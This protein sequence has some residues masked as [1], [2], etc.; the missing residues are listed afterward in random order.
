MLL[1]SISKWPPH[2]LRSL[3][4]SANDLHLS[5][6]IDPIPVLSPMSNCSPRAMTLKRSS[7]LTWI[8]TRRYIPK[9]GTI[10]HF[11]PISHKRYH[12]RPPFP[13]HT[14]SRSNR[15]TVSTTPYHRTILL[16]PSN[17]FLDIPPDLFLMAYISCILRRPTPRPDPTLLCS[18]FQFDL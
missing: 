5:P 18:L 1:S 4:N 2:S 16:T 9:L 12:P 10:S 11:T 15:N 17:D 13:N 6:C 14:S 7:S 8:H 3:F